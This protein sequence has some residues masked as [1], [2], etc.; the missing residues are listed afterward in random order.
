MAENSTPP[1]G[2]PAFKRFK[3]P[4]VDSVA[5]DASLISQKKMAFSS[6]DAKMTVFGT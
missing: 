1:E 5:Q 4:A 6:A 2:Q 3:L